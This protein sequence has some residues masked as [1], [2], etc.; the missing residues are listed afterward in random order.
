MAGDL[1]RI[2]GPAVKYADQK[3][4]GVGLAAPSALRLLARYT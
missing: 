2:S 1:S 3:S 4:L